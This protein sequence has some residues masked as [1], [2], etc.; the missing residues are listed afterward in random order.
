MN[1]KI[2]YVIRETKR[3]TSEREYVYLELV[4]LT[5]FGDQKMPDVVLTTFNDTREAEVFW[6]WL[7]P[8]V[9]A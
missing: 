6:D 9:P 4:R 3:G 8:L 1:A 5:T 7:K 2:T